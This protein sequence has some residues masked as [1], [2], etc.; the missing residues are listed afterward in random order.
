MDVGRTNVRLETIF[1]VFPNAF[2]TTIV[3][4]A[5]LTVRE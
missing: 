2:V 5:P 1:D 3:L 4:V